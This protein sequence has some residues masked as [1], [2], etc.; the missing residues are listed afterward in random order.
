MMNHYET[1]TGRRVPVEKFSR[2][3]RQ[4]FLRLIEEY[5]RSPKWGRFSSVWQRLIAEALPKHSAK[6]RRE[7]A[8][9]KIGQ[10]LELR[11]GIAQGAVAPPDYRDYIVDAIE[12]KFHSRYRFC[13][14]TG[15]PEGFLSQ[16]LAGKKDFS[17]ARLRE[18][19][20]ALDLELVLLPAAEL[21]REATR[22]T[23]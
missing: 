6:E 3:E 17:L 15:V 14:E 5:E 21:R 10:D 1:L 23:L 18:V 13:K 2:K 11:L 12:E 22:L 19:A 16:V 7:N 9:Y 4:V 20:A 8:L